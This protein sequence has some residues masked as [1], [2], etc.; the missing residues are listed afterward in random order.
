MGIDRHHHASAR[1]RET[2]STRVA[3]GWLGSESR[4]TVLTTNGPSNVIHLLRQ[5]ER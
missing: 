2:A 3:F 5:D 1:E 4:G